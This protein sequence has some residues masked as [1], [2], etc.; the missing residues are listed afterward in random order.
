[1]KHLSWR[2][3][4]SQTQWH[5]WKT[6]IMSNLQKNK[7]MVVVDSDFRFHFDLAG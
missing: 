7:L 1:M 6:I 2:C 3:S 4:I 5:T